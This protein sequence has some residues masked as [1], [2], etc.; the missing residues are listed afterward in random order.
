M[1]V[2]FIDIKRFESGLLEEWEEKV[3]ILSKNASFIGGEE[4]S[5]LERNLASQAE[6]KYSVA[7]ANGTD[8]LQLALRALGVGKG[9]AVLLPDSTFWATFE[10]VV[11]VGADPYT[12]DTDPNDLQ[13]DFTVFEKALEKVKP[14][15][16]IIV[17]LYGWGS[18]RLEDFR[19]LCRS[20][21]IPL[22]EDGAQ[23][24]GVKYKGTSIYKGALI[25]TTSFYPAKVLG[26]AGDGGAVFT[27]DEKLANKVRML[28]NHGR[29][30]HYA[31]GDVGW[32]SRL[33][34]LQAAFLNINLKHLEARIVSRRK[35]AQKYYEILPN[36]GIQVI[37][38]PKDYEEN[39]YCNV[40]LAAPE[41]RSVIQEV[42]KEKEIGFGN[43]Y[44]GAMSDQPGAKPYIK[45][46]F[47]DRHTTG[48]I[49][50]SVLNYPLF[51]YMKEEELEEIFSA[52]RVYN[53]KKK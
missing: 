50:A 23:C 28:A 10:S 29:I 1:G 6:T 15:A 45:E 20:K 4:V 42:L 39:G 33:D 34:T 35:I 37:H 31:Y 47:G 18:A 17:H 25:A 43:I 26:G 36:L 38:P 51:P 24:Y 27:N 48:K 8:A 19:K 14:K 46:K 5:L 44:P 11:N 21:E 12:V 41:E 32:N 49:C 16:A 53:S 22:L 30:S 3:K 2:P 13:M 9:D 52:I 40:T 7:C